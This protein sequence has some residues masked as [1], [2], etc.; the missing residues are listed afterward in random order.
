L[1]NRPK[2]LLLDEP[3]GD[4]DTKN[5]DLVMK[6]LLDL[7]INEGITMVLFFFVYLLNFIFLTRLWSHM[8]S[9]SKDM[10]IEL[11]EWSMEKLILKSLSRML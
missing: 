11:L 5:T 6:I 1:A 2:I 10:L 7:N 9:H 3:T 4:L 8:M